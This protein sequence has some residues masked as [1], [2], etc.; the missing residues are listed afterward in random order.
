MKYKILSIIIIIF[1]FKAIA[2][3]ELYCNKDVM[4]GAEKLDSYLHLL[5]NKKIGIVGNQ[6]S[7][8]GET[9]LVDSL[10]AL[11]IDIRKVFSP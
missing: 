6:S 10:L 4:V 1:S 7:M 5:T 3:S 8:I 2:Q 9:H 11:K